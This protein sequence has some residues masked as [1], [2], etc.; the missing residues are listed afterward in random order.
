[1][2]NL[3]KTTILFLLRIVVITSVGEHVYGDEQSAFDCNI[4]NPGCPNVCYS[5][6][7]PISQIR[8][9]GVQ[10]IAVATPGAL[11]VVYTIQS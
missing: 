7:A 3:I 6:F 4:R 10:I 5:K 9:W 8:L 1:M 2:L 11:F